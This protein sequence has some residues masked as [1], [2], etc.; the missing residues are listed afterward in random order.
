MTTFALAL[1]LGGTKLDA[2]LVDPSGTVLAGS[3]ARRA[4][5]RDITP[6]A[7]DEALAAVVA[8]ALTALPADAQVVGAGI[9]SAGPVDRPSGGILPVNM[10]ALVGFDLAAAVARAVRAAGLDVPVVLGHDGGALALAESWIGAAADA[11]AS[12]SI[13]VS[14]GIGGGFVLGGALMTGASGNAGHLGQTLV[15]D[16]TLEEIASGPASI[17]WA[18]AQG[19]SGTT[20]MEL[21]AAAAAGDAIARAAVER[22]ARAVGIGLANASTLVDLDVISIGGGFS[23]VSDDYIEL[24]GTA[25]REAAVL[26]FARRVR[27]VRSALG[28]EGPLIGAAALILRRG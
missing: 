18:R 19:W 8:E 27:V 5:G 17:A 12:L 25:L 22:S 20:G 14:T 21:G 7:L 2:A 6:A 1:D 13:V 11:V 24:V 9:G 26:E 23:H 28:D 16:T 10:P 15:G 3:R 4:T